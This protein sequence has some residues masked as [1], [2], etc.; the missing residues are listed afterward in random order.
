[1]FS[2]RVVDANE[3]LSMGL[4]NRVVAHADVFDETRALARQIADNSLEALIATK[5]VIDRALDATAAATLELEW[6]TKL[7][8][9]PEHHE[10]FKAAAQR[11]AARGDGNAK[12]S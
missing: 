10:R 6:N 5:Q 8:G 9:S 11:V 1:M 12:K 2:G 3:A 4:V 7:R